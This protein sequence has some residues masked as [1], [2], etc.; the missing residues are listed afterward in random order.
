[1]P[2]ARHQAIFGAND[3]L[4]PIVYMEINLSE[5]RSKIQQF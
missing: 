3:S 4:L 1:M 5:V 2:P